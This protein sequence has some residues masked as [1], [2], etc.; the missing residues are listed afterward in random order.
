MRTCFYL[1]CH[2]R[3]TKC[4]RMFLIVPR[5]GTHICL[6]NLM[7]MIVVLYIGSTGLNTDKSY[8][9]YLKTC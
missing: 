3:M 2:F 4:F 1:H 9:V 7:E 8:D 6:D 5:L